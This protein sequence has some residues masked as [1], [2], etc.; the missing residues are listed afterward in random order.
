MKRAEQEAI[1]RQIDEV[2]AAMEQEFN[3]RYPYGASYRDGKRLRSC[4]AEVYETADFYILRSYN[5]IIAAIE[6]S[7]DTC[8]DFLR[9]VYGYTAT[10]AQHI[11]KFQRDYGTGKWGCEN[12]LTW[13]EV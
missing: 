10:S 1:N 11:S 5:T 9:K 7:T 2:I 8:V 6:K 13:R 12:M 3:A 4:S